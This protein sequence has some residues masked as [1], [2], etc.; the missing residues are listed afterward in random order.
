[1][2]VALVRQFAKVRL[3]DARAIVPAIN[4]N[5]R[6]VRARIELAD[7]V[8]ADRRDARAELTSGKE[9]RAMADEFRRLLVN[10]QID[11]EHPHLNAGSLDWYELPQDNA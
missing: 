6:R 4:S 1:M 11:P 3:D 7:T 9:Y 5:Y 8:P 10:K 2:R